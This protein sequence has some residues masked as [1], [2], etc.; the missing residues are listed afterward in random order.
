VLELNE[1]DSGLWTF[2]QALSVMG[3]QIGCRMT[4]LRL[5]SGELLIHS[6]V[7]LTAELRRGLDELG[8]VRHVLA[9][10]ADHYLYINDYSNAYPDAHFY[11]APGV[12]DKLP[13]V[14][15]EMAL[16]HP[17]I[18]PAWTDTVDQRYFRSSGT[19]QELILFHRATRTLITADLAFNVQASGGVLSG[20]MLRL[21]DSYKTFGPSRVCR[22]HITM[23]QVARADLDAILTWSPER[24][25]VSHGEI[26]FSGAEDALRRAYR[27]LR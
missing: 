13:G 11:A 18:V 9:P 10:N 2:H 23:P 17:H 27:W 22:R 26:L 5:P 8:P 4:V 19:L 21:N 12:A 1:A 14:R 16:E 6:P 25:V 3:A 7:G 24:V 15:F 20:I